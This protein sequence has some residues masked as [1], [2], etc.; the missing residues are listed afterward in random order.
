MSQL[1]VFLIHTLIGFLSAFL[2]EP[3]LFL[4]R[5]F[6]KVRVLTDILFFVL[7]AVFVGKGSALFGFP[8]Y[9]TYMSV[10]NLL[11]VI[12]YL[13]SI[14]LLLAFFEKICYNTLVKGKKAF[15]KRK[16]VKNEVNIKL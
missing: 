5:Y 8:N 11:G 7:L 3:L 15:H 14:H 9:R 10:G 2:G 13:K 6:P 1:P 12:L 16:K 4:G